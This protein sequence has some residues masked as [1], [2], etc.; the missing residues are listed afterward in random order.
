[1][2]IIRSRS[3]NSVLQ[4]SQ[5]GSVRLVDDLVFSRSITLLYLL[6]IEMMP[7]LGTYIEALHVVEGSPP[8]CSIINSI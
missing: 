7:T 8:E 5:S 2:A 6:P 4:F 3:F 1:M